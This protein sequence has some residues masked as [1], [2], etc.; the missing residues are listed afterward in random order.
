VTQS[1]AATGMLAVAAG[2]LCWLLT[3]LYRRTMIAA[4]RVEAPNARS[5][6]AV[7]VPVG[8]GIAI[9]VV[10]L[11]LWPLSQGLVLQSRHLMLGAA[12][13]GLAALS[14]VDDRQGLSPAVR[15]A[16]QVL[17]IAVLLTWLEPELRVA[18]V[19]PLVVERLLLALAW[20][21]FVNL[22]NF[23]DGIDGL[24]GSEAIAITAGYLLVAALAGLDGPLRELT[25]IIA[26]ATAG[27]LVWNWH[28]A[29][30]FMG[31]AG[32]IPLGFLLGWLMI[33]LAVNGHWLPAVILPAYFVADAT[34]TLAKRLWHGRK[35]WEAHRAHFYQRAVLGGATSLMV[36]RCVN[37]TNVMLLGLALLSLGHPVIALAGAIAVTAALLIHLERLARGYG[38]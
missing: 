18:P 8:A 10:A 38:S 16:A 21:W 15:L 13:A 11:C 34:L 20:L 14:W 31:D 19:L 17:A 30:V 29:R 26:A 12:L 25:L 7:P 37:A 33:D 9:I 32:S 2:L 35:P 4:G 5:M 22:F 1:L 28:P 36:V 23:M 27:Y 6:H 3:G 24:A